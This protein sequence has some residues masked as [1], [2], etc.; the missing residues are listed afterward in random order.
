MKNNVQKDPKH[1][2]AINYCDQL[3]KKGALTGLENL[4][5]TNL[6]VSME[7]IHFHAPYEEIT[8]SVLIS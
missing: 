2:I 3:F 5:L 1:Q 4:R 8:K 7:K 6:F